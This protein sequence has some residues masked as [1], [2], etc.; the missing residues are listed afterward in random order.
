MQYPIIQ[1]EY[2]STD[3]Q[4]YQVLDEVTNKEKKG[5]TI[6]HRFEAVDGTQVSLRE[7][8]P[9]GFNPDTYKSSYEKGEV[10]N[11]QLR[12]FEVKDKVIHGRL[13]A[14]LPL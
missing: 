11:V 9:Q 6:T 14:A 7:A 12:Q 3:V 2:R 1:L 4:P 13:F 10:Y 8:L 5:Y